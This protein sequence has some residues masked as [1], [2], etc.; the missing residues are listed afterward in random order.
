MSNVVF[1][2]EKKISGSEVSNKIR[3]IADGLEK[4]EINLKAGGE[5]VQLKPSRNCE[6]EL[7]VEEESDGEK[8]LEIEIEWYGDGQDSELNIG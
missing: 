1:K 8:S 4:G 5:S 7:K 3:K 6:F 2:N